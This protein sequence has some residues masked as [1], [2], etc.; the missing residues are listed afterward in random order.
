MTKIAW[1]TINGYGP[2][3]YLQET[4]KKADGTVVSNHLAYLGK[5]GPDG[6]F[7]NQQYALWPSKASGKAGS[8]TLVALLPQEVQHNLKPS[9][10]FTPEQLKKQPK[11]GLAAKKGPHAVPKAPAPAK[12]PSKPKAP[13][14]A[15]L[16]GKKPTPTPSTKSL[17]SVANVKKLM[18]AAACGDAEVLEWAGDQIQD[19]LQ[20]KAKKAAIAELVTA[21]KADL[22][23]DPGGPPE[24]EK[25]AKEAS[26]SAKA[27]VDEKPG[28]GKAV[29]KA[30]SAQTAKGAP[31]PAAA[32]AAAEAP[33]DAKGKPLIADGNLQALEEA[34]AEGVKTLEAVGKALEAKAKGQ[35]KKAAVANQVAALKAQELGTPAMEGEG[36]SDLPATIEAVKSGEQKLP[37]QSVP[38]AKVAQE[39][40]DQILAGT[41]EWDADLEKVSGK[42]GSNEGGLFKDKKLQSFHYIKWP[43]SEARARVEA[44]VGLLYSYAGVPVPM[45]RPVQF[46]GQTAVMSDWIEGAS[47]ITAAQMAKH[48]DVRE[49]FVIDAWLANWDVVGMSADNI[50]TGDGDKAYRIDLGGSLIFRAQGKGKPLPKEVGELESMTNSDVNPATAKVFGGLKS[51]ELKAGAKKLAE[52]SDHQIDHAVELMEIPKTSPQYPAAQFGSEAKDLPQLLKDR[53]KQRRDFIVSAVLHAKAKKQEALA[54]LKKDL[55]LKSAAIDLLAKK[56]QSITHHTHANTKRALQ[57]GLLESELGKAKGQASAHVVSKS[58][59]EWKSSTNT[60]GGRLLRWGTGELEGQGDREIRRMQK[61]NAHKAGKSAQAAKALQGELDQVVAKAASKDGHL[62]V[63]G[64]RVTRQAN[65]AMVRLQEPGKE[66]ITVYR[67]WPA[68]QVQFLKLHKATVEDVLDLEDPP[69]Y[70]WT[71]DPGVFSSVSHGA[72]RTKSDV[73]IDKIVLTDKM[74]NTTGALAGEQEVLFKGV[75]N[76]KMEVVKA[77]L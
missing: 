51:A 67:T 23:C 55:S 46:Q 13:L 9:E 52:V 19:K 34:A 65:E 33:K 14:G 25:A 31:P 24:S 8:M 22:P 12:H 71:L 10:T 3:A 11:I 41:K 2:Y 76:H 5:P 62:L 74:N 40:E 72:I 43:G 7:P 56:A 61:F 32:G 77:S 58:Y 50:V 28:V 68:D 54:A 26:P 57:V 20:S 66:H 15:T 69:A 47:P 4:V 21:L 17:V 30:K 73:P 44:L 16:P 38:T 1:K 49:N 45:I 42:K 75:K 53:L 6:L 35:A 48:K 70:S 64:L 18:K 63:E 37:E 59:S 60:P 39:Q 29:K 36:E 27:K